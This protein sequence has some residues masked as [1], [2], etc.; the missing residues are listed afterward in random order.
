MAAACDVDYNLHMLAEPVE[1]N[2]RAFEAMLIGASLL[3]A[4]SYTDGWP[5]LEKK[6][7]YCCFRG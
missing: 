5:D 6:G 2:H 4:Y 1:A 3:F 7:R